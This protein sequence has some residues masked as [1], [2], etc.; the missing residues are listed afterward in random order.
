M[1][2]VTQRDQIRGVCKAWREQYPLAAKHFADKHEIYHRLC[3]LNLEQC[4]AEDVNDIIG[5]V[6]WTSLRCDEC[7]QETD[8]LL[9]VG[10]PPDYESRTARLCK[11]CCKQVA[12]MVARKTK[13]KQN[14]QYAPQN[15][16]TANG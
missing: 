9:Y 15:P 13:T 6:S 5:N 1:N 4:R 14:N 3:Q 7:N 11:S 12:Q 10:E 2:I 16:P 8:W